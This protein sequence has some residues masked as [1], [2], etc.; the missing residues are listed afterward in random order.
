MAQIASQVVAAIA[1]DANNTPA[2][3][4]LPQLAGVE[5]VFTGA[6]GPIASQTSQS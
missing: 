4:A 5:S 6:G 3:S 1:E 2:L